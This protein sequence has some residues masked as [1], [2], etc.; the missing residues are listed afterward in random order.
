MNAPLECIIQKYEK[1]T[2]DWKIRTLP[3]APH[4]QNLRRKTG[5]RAGILPVLN[6]YLY[7]KVKKVCKKS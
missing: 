5:D 3:P 4:R 7:K 6:F 1:S 2:V